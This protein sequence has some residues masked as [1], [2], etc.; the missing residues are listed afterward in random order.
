MPEKISK[1]LL[2][3]TERMES[4]V[5]F[6]AAGHSKDEYVKALFTEEDY[7][8]VTFLINGI[9]FSFSQVCKEME[10]QWT[11]R[12]E[13][14]NKQIENRAKDLID[15]KLKPYFNLLERVKKVLKREITRK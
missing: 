12:N 10:K 13:K 11:E 14:L 2:R 9:E 15:E 1:D 3:N 8:E 5:I 4:W 6:E 7:V